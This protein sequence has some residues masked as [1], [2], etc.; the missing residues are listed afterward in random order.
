MVENF[1]RRIYGKKHILAEKI[2]DSRSEIQEVIENLKKLYESIYTLGR[3]EFYSSHN[4]E[5]RKEL[6]GKSRYIDEA[7]RKYVSFIKVKERIVSN[8]DQ[9]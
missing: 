1:K 2:R 4:S 3:D 8:G 5:I 6:V 7:I 9:R